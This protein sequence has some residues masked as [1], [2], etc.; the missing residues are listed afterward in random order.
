MRIPEP[1]RHAVRGVAVTV[2][3]GIAA[4]ATAAD[5]TTVVIGATSNIAA[6]NPYADSASQMYSIW[7]NDYG[8]LCRYDFDKA[9]YEPMLAERWENDPGNRNVWT[10]HLRRDVRSHNGAPLTAADVVHTYDRIRNDRQSAQRAQIQPIARVV[11][12]DEH[13]VQLITKQPTAPLLQYV[14][15]SQVITRKAVFDQYGARDADRLHPDGFGP[16][17]LAELTIGE[18]VVLEKDSTS[19]FAHKDNPDIL[20]WRRMQE[21]E[22]RITALLNGEIQIAQY[23]PPHMMGRVERNPKIK[24]GY[25]DTVEIMFLAMNPTFKPWDNKKLRQAVAYAIDRPA[26][27]K[28][29]LGGLATP[30]HGPVGPGQYGYD[31]ERATAFDIPYDPEKAKQLVKEAGYPDGLDV[32]LFSATG[33]YVNDKQVAEAMAAMLTGVGIRTRLHTPEYATYWPQVQKGKVPFYYQGRGSMIDPSVGIAQYFETGVTPRVGYS[34]PA[35]DKLLRA[36]REEFD[37]AKRKK[38]MN[39]AFAILIDDVPAHF[40]WRH[41]LV[42]AMARNVDYQ[43]LPHNRVYGDRVTVH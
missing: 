28:S 24:L 2:V 42:D 10:F 5:K 21:P 36:E 17:R 33:R 27:I 41:R 18:R 15:D 35:L 39:D 32:D 23:V 3:F 43:P 12:M 9:D 31:A 37:P 29:I 34:N 40:L 19:P 7:T 6:Y 16:Y 14:C 13:T 8:A 4:A 20:M 11:A 25:T 1:I 38:L 26:I 30:L 22:Q